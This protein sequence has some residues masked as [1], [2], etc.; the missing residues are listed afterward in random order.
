MVKK[1]NKNNSLEGVYIRC[2]KGNFAQN[3]LS[4][5]KKFSKISLI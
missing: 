2:S 1:F 4:R 5:M 3:S